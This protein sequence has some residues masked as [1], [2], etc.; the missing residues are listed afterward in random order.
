MTTR[1]ATKKNKSNRRQAAN[2]SPRLSPLPYLYDSCLIFCRLNHRHHHDHDSQD[3]LWPQLSFPIFSIF[4]LR[5]PA[6]IFDDLSNS[7]TLPILLDECK[8]PNRHL[9]SLAYFIPT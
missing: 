5:F 1:T 2:S 4:L 7:N 3:S 8:H 6:T 9:V